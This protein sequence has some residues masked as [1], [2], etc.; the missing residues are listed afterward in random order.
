MLVLG[1][2]YQNPKRISETGGRDVLVAADAETVLERIKQGPE[3]TILFEHETMRMMMAKRAERVE[4]LRTTLG[5]NSAVIPIRK[6]PESF[7]D[8]VTLGRAGTAD[9]VIDDPAISNVHAHFQ[10]DADGRLA[11]VQD[12]GSSNGTHINRVPVQPHTLAALRSGDVVRFGQT[13]FYF[14]GKSMFR[15]LV[16]GDA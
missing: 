7:W 8:H 6:K 12:L 14:V 10:I 13:V 5:P 16:V 9:I 11:G 15:S 3:A 1:E 2:L 4:Q